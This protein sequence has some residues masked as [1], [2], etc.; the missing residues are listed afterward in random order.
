[1]NHEE[2]A[3][4]LEQHGVKPTAV[5]MLVWESISACHDAFTLKDVEESQPYMDRSSIFRALRLFAEHHII[6]EIDDGTGQCKYCLCRCDNNMHRGHVHFSCTECGKTYCLESTGIPAV[7]IP[8]GFRM[9]EAEYVIKGL[10]DQCVASA[11][12]RG[13]L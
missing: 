6:H 10:C 7:S 5:R 8:D 3:K 11:A 4:F 2:A 9:E 12:K 1:M 13:E